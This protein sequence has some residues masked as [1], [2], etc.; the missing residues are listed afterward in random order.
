MLNTLL[1]KMLEFKL[2]DGKPGQFQGYGSTFDN[3]DLGKDKCVKGCF[4][5][6]LTEHKTDNTLP[7][8]YWMHDPKEP[9]G[10]W[11]EV[12]ED[13]KGLFVSGQLWTGTQ[14]TEC[15]RKAMNL[16]K[17]TGPKGLSIGYKTEKQTYDQKS[18]VRSL[19]DVTLRE[20]SVV[21]YGMNQ[22]ALVTH[23]KSLFVDGEVPTVRDVEELLRDA[24]FSASQA[25]SFIANGYKAVER[26]AD[27]Q[28]TMS[29]EI[30]ELL[31]LR[32]ALRCDD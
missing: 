6:T 29:E 32:A 5:R 12:R 16:L 21:G 14:E 15:S 20:L 23:I 30:Q 17:G 31:R 2:D 24:G 1:T 27:N 25:K 28:K 8:M 9:I 10:D 3:V 4:A 11:T 18:G 22:K 19:H 7:A 26:D 13:S